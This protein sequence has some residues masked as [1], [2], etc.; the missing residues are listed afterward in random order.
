M[1]S[2][3]AKVRVVGYS[4][5]RKFYSP[6]YKS[7]E[8]PEKLD[9]F[10]KTLYW[11]P[12]VRTFSDGKAQVSFYNSDETGTMNVIVEGINAEGKLCRGT[13]SYNV[14]Y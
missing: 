3:T 11:D 6:K 7:N 14:T 12:L 10:R 1:T 2:G 4:V 8:V 13:V 9:D 5:F